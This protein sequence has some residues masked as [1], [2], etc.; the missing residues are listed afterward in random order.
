MRYE[1]ARSP[2][3]AI[4]AAP[5]GVHKPLWNHGNRPRV[6][7]FSLLVSL[8]RGVLS[9]IG[10]IQRSLTQLGR[11]AAHPSAFAVLILYAA[12]WILLQPESFDLHAVATLATWFMTLLIQRAEHRDTQAIH[13]KLDELLHVNREARNELTRIDEA[14]PEDVVKFRVEERRDDDRPEPLDRNRR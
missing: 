12:G 13:A 1:I 6:L 9:M 7:A 4:G 8:E 2:G 14:E 5:D 11:L 3:A 10:S